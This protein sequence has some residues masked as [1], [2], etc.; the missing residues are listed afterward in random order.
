MSSIGSFNLHPF[1]SRL[2]SHS[3]LSAEDRQG[4]LAL[5]FRTMQ[6]AARRDFVPLGQPVDH[7]CFIVEGFVSRFAQST[8]GARQVTAFHIAG[9]MADLHSLVLP[10][11]TQGLHAITTTTILSVPHAALRELT[12]S[13]P[14]IAEAFWRECMIDAAITAQWVVNVGRRDAKTRVAHLLCEM[15]ERYGAVERPGCAYDLPITQADLADATGLTPVHVNRVL[16]VLRVEGLAVCRSGEVQIVDRDGLESAG[17][18]D[19]AYLGTGPAKARD[20]SLAAGG[21][22]KLKVC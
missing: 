17:D 3:H 8:E 20:G 1:F 16:K 5:P 18:F 22:M 2:S 19:P 7:A 15:A 9:D 14:S 21:E 6:I 12:R 11:P 4:L 10:N 13:S